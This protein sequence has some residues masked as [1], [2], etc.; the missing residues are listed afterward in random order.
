MILT[1]DGAPAG[2]IE[3]IMLLSMWARH[4]AKHLPRSE[5]TIFA[6]M[7]RPTYPVNQHAVTAEQK[8]WGK[9]ADLIETANAFLKTASTSANPEEHYDSVADMQCAID[10]GDPM[11]DI[12]AR[13]NRTQRVVGVTK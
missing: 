2:A 1:P 7:G 3:K 8:Y 6:G 13:R 11:G 9:V 10:Y 4:L 12:D 5:K